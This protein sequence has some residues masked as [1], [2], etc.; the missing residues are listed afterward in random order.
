MAV[1]DLASGRQEEGCDDDSVVVLEGQR[2]DN[3]GAEEQGF[4]S[5]MDGFSEASIERPAAFGYENWRKFS[6]MHPGRPSGMGSLIF[7][8]PQTWSRPLFFH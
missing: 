5:Q 1:W 4:D 8:S 6:D 3:E 2:M 7:G